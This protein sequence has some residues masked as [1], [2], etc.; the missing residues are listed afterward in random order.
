MMANFTIMKK[1]V[2]ALLAVIHQDDG[3]H[4]AKVG[5]VQSIRDAIA[6]IVKE[7]QLRAEER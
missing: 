2:K 4:T 7:R 6:T 3:H 5:Y 1:E